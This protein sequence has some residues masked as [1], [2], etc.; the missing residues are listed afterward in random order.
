MNAQKPTSLPLIQ[1]GKM[2]YENL[3]KAGLNEPWLRETL[4]QLQ[5]Y[6]LRDVRFA[7][8]DESGGVHVLYA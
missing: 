7:L 5:I 4:S 1:A 2:C 6:D 3:M 8:L